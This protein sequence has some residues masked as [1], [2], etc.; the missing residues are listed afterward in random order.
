MT[1]TCTWFVFFRWWSSKDNGRRTTDD[2]TV[3]G[4]GSTNRAHRQYRWVIYMY[5]VGVTVTGRGSTTRLG[6]QYRWVIYVVVSLW[7][8]GGLQQ[9]LDINTGGFIKCCWCHCDRSDSHRTGVYRY[10]QDWMVMQVSPIILKE[11]VQ[12]LGNVCLQPLFY[13]IFIENYPKLDS[14]F[15]KVWTIINRAQIHSLKSLFV[16]FCTRQ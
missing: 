11:T 12:D 3:T 7:Q 15:W 10:S 1:V 5:V 9:G 16:N 8:D 2:Q 14:S 4:R 6:R 13:M